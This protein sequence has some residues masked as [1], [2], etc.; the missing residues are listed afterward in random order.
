[1][2]SGATQMPFALFLCLEQ[3]MGSDAFKK[4]NQTAR[5]SLTARLWRAAEMQAAEIEARLAAGARPVAES[6][7]DARMLSVLA[8]TLRE[9]SAASLIES[10]DDPEDED[11]APDDLD[12]LREALGERLR[13]I[14]GERTS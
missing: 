10:D 2:K 13:R 5:A 9:L 1:M 4:Q 11:A 14:A 12:E 3:S 7:R 8:K 6:E